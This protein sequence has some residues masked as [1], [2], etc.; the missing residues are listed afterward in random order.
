MNPQTQP[1]PTQKPV[2]DVI[3]HHKVTGLALNSSSR[4]ANSDSITCDKWTICAAVWR[5]QDWREAKGDEAPDGFGF[6]Q[7]AT[8]RQT[9]KSYL[10]RGFVTMSQVAEV[11]FGSE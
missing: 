9:H 1:Q 2:S 4:I 8:D 6:S 11:L 10:R 3:E 7:R 5:G